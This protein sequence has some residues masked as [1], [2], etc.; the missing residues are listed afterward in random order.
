[1]VPSDLSQS[2]KL[3]RKVLTQ[4][5]FAIIADE[6]KLDQAKASVSLENERL[7]TRVGTRWFQKRQKREN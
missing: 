5:S 3:E 6:G 1:M 4:E 2:I 7:Q